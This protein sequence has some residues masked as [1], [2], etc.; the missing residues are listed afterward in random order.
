MSR[1]PNNLKVNPYL[2]RVEKAGKIEDSYQML[3]VIGKGGYGEVR[4]IRNIMTNEI[5][6]VK[7]IAK[8]RCQ[9]SALFSDEIQILQKL[10]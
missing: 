2:F 9:K 3:D 4:R 5:R 7:I 10:V 8:S 1:V 6:A